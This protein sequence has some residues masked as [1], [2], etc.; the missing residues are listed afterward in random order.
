VEACDINAANSLETLSYTIGGV[1]GPAIAGFLIAQVGAPL[2]V[3]VDVAS[4]FIFALLLATLNPSGPLRLPTAATNPAG[5]G[6]TFRIVSGTPVL[7][8]TTLSSLSST[9]AKAR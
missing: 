5:Y 4:Y 8:S 7:L 6:A 1:A 9:L 3:L 2:T